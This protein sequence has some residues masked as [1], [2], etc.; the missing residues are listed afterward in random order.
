MNVA[1]KRLIAP[2]NIRTSFSNDPQNDGAKLEVDVY[3][4]TTSLGMFD[5]VIH[6]KDLVTLYGWQSSS[7]D[8]LMV[9]GEYMIPI[10]L[11]WRRTRRRETSGVAN[12]VQSIQ[13]IQSIMDKKVLFGIWSSRMEPFE[14][15]VKWLSNEKVVCVSCFESIES[16]VKMTLDT[17]TTQYSLHKD[18]VD[19][20]TCCQM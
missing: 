8:Q 9:I 4:G 13:H 10:Q 7:I 15:N 14:D 17:I 20:H 2:S 1:A 3:K 16:L 18:V 6:E 11:K 19:K 5:Y 12:F